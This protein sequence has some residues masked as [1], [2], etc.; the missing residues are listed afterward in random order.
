MSE[1]NKAVIRRFS[2]AIVDYWRT[3]NDGVFDQLLAPDFKVR[4]PGMP[5]VESREA[6]KQVLAMFRAG[7]SDLENRFEN[8]TADGDKVAYRGTWSALHT[9]E[10]MGIPPTGKRVTVTEMHIAR[11][12]GGKIVE[13]WGV[14]DMLGLMQ[15]LGVAPTPG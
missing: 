12:A 3:G 5:P 8:L 15:Q 14:L 6:F 1:Q 4:L 9:G 10:L 2:D 13:R 11:L 7:M